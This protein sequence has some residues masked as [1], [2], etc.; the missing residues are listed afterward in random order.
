MEGLFSFNENWS[1]RTFFL[2]IT[3]STIISCLCYY[4]LNSRFS[5]YKIKYYGSVIIEKFSIH[6]FLSIA[7]LTFIATIRS[8]QVGTDTQGYIDEFLYSQYLDI[9]VIRIM[10]FHEMEPGY[11][12]LLYV[13]RSFTDNYHILFFIIYA[14]LSAAYV[15][16]IKYFYRKNDHFIFLLYFIFLFTSNMSG[17][18]SAIAMI[19][20]LPSFIL[21]DKNK[22]KDACFF[23]IIAC[24][25]HYTYLYN[26]FV[27]LLSKLCKENKNKLIEKKAWLIGL[28]GAFL[29]AALG[30]S[31]VLK[32]FEETK[33]S[34]YTNKA[35]E[36][37]YLGSM[38]FV[39]YGVLEFLYY[40]RIIKLD[41]RKYTLL[42]ISLSFI[43]LYPLL[44]ITGAYRIANY[45]AMPRLVIWDTILS[46]ILLNATSKSKVIIELSFIFLLIL[47]L[48]FRFS[49][50]AADG[51]FIYSI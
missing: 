50:S 24:T 19:F 36:M 45:Y 4:S 12:L 18:R 44:F 33:Y 31:L 23:T 39:I 34:F 48:L 9:D 51:G 1:W 28:S 3:I 6:D 13:V 22:Y 37:T 17:M 7:L 20:L 30:S 21:I 46:I 5:K 15:S 43:V 8:S 35:E 38:I 26:F 40:D 32:L 29:V 27:I 47:Y 42:V 25:F 11:R 10:T 41:S 14:P 2:Y 49:K 16:F